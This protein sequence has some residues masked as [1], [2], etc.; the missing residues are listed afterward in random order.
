MIPEDLLLN[1]LRTRPVINSHYRVA[2][3]TASGTN[4]DEGTPAATDRGEHRSNGQPGKRIARD[5]EQTPAPAANIPM[6]DPTTHENEA[7]SISTAP[8]PSYKS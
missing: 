6:A 2:P 5:P 3:F 1:D 4:G 8:P 7:L